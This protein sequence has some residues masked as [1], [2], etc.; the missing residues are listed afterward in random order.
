MNIAPT[1]IGPK[2]PQ[3]RASLHVRISG[4]I[5]LRAKMI[6]I[7]RNTRIRMAMATRRH[8]T[9]VSSGAFIISHGMILP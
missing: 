8:G 7:R 9:I 6:G 1:P 5:G 3:N 4:M 2:C